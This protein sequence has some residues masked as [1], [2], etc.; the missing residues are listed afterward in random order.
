M[1]I[2]RIMR[3]GNSQAVAIPSAYLRELGWAIG[4][5]LVFERYDGELRLRLLV[6]ATGR[7]A[8]TSYRGRPA[9]EQAQV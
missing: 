1:E 4:D 2:R 6:I 8:P 3:R 9:H 7:P 5:Q